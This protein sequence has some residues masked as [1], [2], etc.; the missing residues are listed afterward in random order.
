DAYKKYTKLDVVEY[1][2]SSFVAIRDNPG[3]PGVGGWQL[4]SR[5]G[6]RGAVGEVGPRGRQGAR[7]ARGE[8][9]PTI[10][11]WTRD[12]RNYV[13][14]PTLS[15]GRAGAP[16]NLRPMFERFFEETGQAAE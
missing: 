8:D 11:A 15:D 6:R 16:L 9:A 1:D 7:G 4:L 3:I 2:G 5:S 12:L 10:V 13:A 14:H